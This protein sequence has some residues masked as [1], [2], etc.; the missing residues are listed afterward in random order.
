MNRTQPPITTTDGALRPVSGRKTATGVSDTRDDANLRE[1]QT[2]STELQWG[3]RYSQSD[4][5]GPGGFGDNGTPVWDS[6]P[7]PLEDGSGLKRPTTPDSLFSYA[8]EAPF[9]WEDPLGLAVCFYYVDTHRLWCISDDGGTQ[10][11]TSQTWSGRGRC[12]DTP[13]CESTINFGPIPDGYWDTGCIGCTPPHTTPRVPI[14]PQPGTQT[15]GRG[16]FQFHVGTGPNASAGCIVMP[17]VV[18]QDFLDFYRLDNSGT[19]QVVVPDVPDLSGWHA[20][21]PR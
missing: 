10:F 18:Y 16:P 4:P 2:F 15:H 17:P 9:S 11:D 12:R 3:V 20:A 21:R 6:L 14:T 7:M 19:L 1:R 5:I 8:R 13:S